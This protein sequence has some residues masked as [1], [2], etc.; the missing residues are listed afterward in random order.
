MGREIYRQNSTDSF[1]DPAE[2][3]Q[4]R[5]FTIN[6][7]ANNSNVG[8]FRKISFSSDDQC[9]TVDSSFFEITINNAEHE[10]HSYSTCAQ[11][12][13]NFVKEH[14]HRNVKLDLKNKISEKNRQ[15]R[16]NSQLARAESF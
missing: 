5:K 7:L 8:H 13:E 14:V 16:L 12:Y 4:F 6:S 1:Q 3:K 10:E 11:V 9:S 15:K 2:P